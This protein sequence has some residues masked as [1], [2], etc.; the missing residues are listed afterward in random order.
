M[1]VHVCISNALFVHR[2][3]VISIFGLTRIPPK[4]K[5][6]YIILNNDIIISL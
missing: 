3:F 5:T 4:F 1:F 2:G 6:I